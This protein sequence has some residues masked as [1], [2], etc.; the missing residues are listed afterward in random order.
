MQPAPALAWLDAFRRLRQGQRDDLVSRLAAVEPV[1]SPDGPDP[2]IPLRPVLMRRWHLRQQAEVG[3]TLIGLLTAVAHRRAGGDPRRL[4]E[5]LGEEP[6]AGEAPRLAPADD[7]TWCATVHPREGVWWFTDFERRSPQPGLAAVHTVATAHATCLV[8]QALRVAGASLGPSDPREVRSRTRAAG[9]P[10][11]ALEVMTRARR[12]GRPSTPEDRWYAN[13]LLL[14]WLYEARGELG[15]RHAGLIERHVPAT[16]PVEDRDV[17][18][19]GVRTPL[20]RHLV[21]ARARYVL[22]SVRP[23]DPPGTVLGWATGGDA[24]HR[25]LDEAVGRRTWMVAQRLVPPGRAAVPVGWPDGSWRLES[26]GTRLEAHYCGTEYAGALV[27]LLG[28]PSATG[29]GADGG[30]SAVLSLDP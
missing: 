29:V 18:V 23:G 2:G 6:S 22:R 21:A 1:L 14:A 16:Y 5:L 19:D 24:W 30:L 11:G 4:G 9:T 7:G 13:R 3:G 8:A 28:P 20:L 10:A 27:R 25:A 26:L 12:T 17:V 15:P